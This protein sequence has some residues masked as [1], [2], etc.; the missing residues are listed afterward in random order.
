MDHHNSNDITLLQSP[1]H[2]YCNYYYS[3]IPFDLNISITVNRTTTTTSMITITITI[4]DANTI[5]MTVTLTTLRSF[6]VYCTTTR[7]ADNNPIF[8]RRISTPV[9]PVFACPSIV[10]VSGKLSQWALFNGEGSCHGSIFGGREPWAQGAC[11]IFEPRTARP[12]IHGLGFRTSI[13]LRPP[14]S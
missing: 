7:N 10:G 13:G 3:Y 9:H 5:T 14:E 12:Q 11:P 4:S 8:G 1:L 2:C 6:P